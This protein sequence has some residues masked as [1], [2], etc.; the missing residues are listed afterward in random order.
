MGSQQFSDGCGFYLLSQNQPFHKKLNLN[1][2]DAQAVSS[3][4]FHF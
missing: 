4:C 1:Q 2:I 3:L